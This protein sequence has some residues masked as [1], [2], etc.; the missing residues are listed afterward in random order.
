MFAALR[1][2]PRAAV[3]VATD[4][5]MYRMPAYQDAGSVLGALASH[6]RYMSLYT[7]TEVLQKNRIEFASINAG[8]R[9][10]RFRNLEDLPV[11]RVEETLRPRFG[12]WTAREALRMMSRS[13]RQSKSGV[14][15]QTRPSGPGRCSRG[16]TYGN[17]WPGRQGSQLDRGDRME[18]VIRGQRGASLDTIIVCTERME[19][20]ASFYQKALELGPYQPSQLHLGQS[21]GPVYFGFDQVERCDGTAPSRVSVWF[22]VDDLQATFERVVA[23]GAE[24]KYPPTEKPWGARLAAVLDPDGNTLGL[25]Q[26]RSGWQ[27]T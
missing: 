26:R 14:V 27:K 4:S 6:R 12:G 11:D 10:S 5:K 20:M 16:S 24:V 7:D 2:L 8:K 21:I 1:C 23:L 22:T 15:S 18:S 25:S 9:C 3:P 17:R 13:A 19:E